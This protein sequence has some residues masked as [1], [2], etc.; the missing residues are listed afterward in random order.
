MDPQTE[1]TLLEAA[2]TSIV[3][4][5]VQDVTIGTRKYTYLSI[6]WLTARMDLLRAQVL[7]QTTGAFF[8]S[9]FRRPE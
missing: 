3:T 6:N 2:Y 4:G 1:L 5:Q 9:Q 8:V 7:R